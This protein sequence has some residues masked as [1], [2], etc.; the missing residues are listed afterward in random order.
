MDITAKENAVIELYRELS[1]LEKIA[2]RA[3]LID[4]DAKL[5]TLLRQG[6]H[7]LDGLAR[8]FIAPHGEND[9]ALVFR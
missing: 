4:G 2:F 7:R 5:L 1:P 3:Y 9:L 8:L 6:S